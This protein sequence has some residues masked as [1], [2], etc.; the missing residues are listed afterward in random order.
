MHLNKSCWGKCLFT[1]TCLH[2]C[3]QSHT[4]SQFESTGLQRELLETGR[5]G[6]Q[7]SQLLL[8]IYWLKGQG[9]RDRQSLKQISSLILFMLTHVFKIMWNTLCL[10]LT[11]HCCWSDSLLQ[12]VLI[13]V[14]WLKCWLFYFF[15]QCVNYLL[16]KLGCGLG[17]RECKSF[18]SSYNTRLFTSLS[19]LQQILVNHW[20]KDRAATANAKSLTA[21]ERRNKE[22]NLSRLCD[23]SEVRLDDTTTL[24]LTC[25]LSG[26]S[27]AGWTVWSCGCSRCYQHPAKVVSH[28]LAGYTSANIGLFSSG[29]IMSLNYFM[30]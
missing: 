6:Q 2:I 19:S 26:W 30:E 8:D 16:T 28:A 9:Q 22:R 18:H 21:E 11:E 4:N 13:K 3:T 15:F 23:W 24:Y 14:L 5:S 12:A 29:C 1:F 25:F 20:L 10:L 7:E 17:I 27:P